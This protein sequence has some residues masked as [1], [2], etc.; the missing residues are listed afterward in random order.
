[1]TFA[2]LGY[3]DS[4]SSSNVSTN[5]W[6]LKPA[7]TN[8]TRAGSAP[9]RSARKRWVSRTEWHNPNTRRSAVASYT[10]HG[11]IAIGLA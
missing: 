11:S 3:S 6:W 7:V 9:T 8:R 2:S 5:A 4:P 1:M 10:A